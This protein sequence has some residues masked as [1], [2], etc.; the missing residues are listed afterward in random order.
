MRR[1][2]PRSAGG[3]GLTGEG[4]ARPRDGRPRRAGVYEDERHI[5][6]VMEVCSGGELFDR[7]IA[8]GHYSEQDAAHLIKQMLCLCKKP[9]LHF[10]KKRMKLLKVFRNQLCLFNCDCSSN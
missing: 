3:R 1:R 9:P 4:G 5:H 2:V 8:K 6:I 10:L 7:I